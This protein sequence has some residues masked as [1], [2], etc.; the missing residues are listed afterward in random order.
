MINVKS[1]VI[2]Q[3]DVA[4]VFLLGV[5]SEAEPN[6]PRICVLKEAWIHVNIAFSSDLP[7]FFLFLD[8]NTSRLLSDC[9]DAQPLIEY[10]ILKKHFPE[11]SAIPILYTNISTR[12]ALSCSLK[13]AS[14]SSGSLMD[15]KY[16]SSPR[17]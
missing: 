16:R 17:K 15:Y 9:G 6:E 12:S 1:V 3:E 13:E 2:R 8:V 11:D 10:V 14:Q 5:R 7:G 4:N